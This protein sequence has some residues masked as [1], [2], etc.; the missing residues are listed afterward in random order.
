MVFAIK[1]W[2]NQ[3]VYSHDCSPEVYYVDGLLLHF[4]TVGSSPDIANATCTQLY[5]HIY[6]ETHGYYV[7]ICEATLRFGYVR[8]FPRKIY[9][10]LWLDGDRPRTIGPSSID[11]DCLFYKNLR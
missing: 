3:S 8:P 11:K 4:I 10:M 2:W 5:F 6:I 7:L 1:S 9:F